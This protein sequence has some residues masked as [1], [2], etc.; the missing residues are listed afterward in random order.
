MMSAPDDDRKPLSN[1]PRPPM[2]RRTLLALAAGYVT[3]LM[4]KRGVTAE[5]IEDRFYCAKGL[6]AEQHPAEFRRWL[7][8]CAY[9]NDQ[10]HRD[11]F[12]AL[13]EAW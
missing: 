2:A 11:P 8:D 13:E 1:L 9:V 4:R 12:K 10:L 7:A 5:F 3:Y 6:H